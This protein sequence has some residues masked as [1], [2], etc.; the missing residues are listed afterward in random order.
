M[1]KRL[2]L[3][4]SP[5]STC[6]SVPLRIAEAIAAEAVGYCIPLQANQSVRDVGSEFTGGAKPTRV[7]AKQRLA[8]RD[9]KV[10]RS[11]PILRADPRATF[12][13]T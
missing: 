5:K 4:I 11:K 9:D 13:I 7:L 8:K 3:T 12:L 1:C 2:W 6:V 10:A